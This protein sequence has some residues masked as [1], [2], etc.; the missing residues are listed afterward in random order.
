MEVAVAKPAFGQTI[1]IR[2]LNRTAEAADMTKSH[3]VKHNVDD[4]GGTL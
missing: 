2:R 1:D 3:I 4:I